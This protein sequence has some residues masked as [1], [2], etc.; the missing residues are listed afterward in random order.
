MRV[1]HSASRR[2]RLF[3]LLAVS[4]FLASVLA[5]AIADT[6]EDAHRSTSSMH[7]SADAPAIKLYPPTDAEG[8]IPSYVKEFTASNSHVPIYVAAPAPI[9]QQ[10]LQEGA[11][12]ASPAPQGGRHDHAAAATRRKREHP[13]SSSGGFASFARRWLGLRAPRGGDVEAE[14]PPQ[15]DVGNEDLADP[16]L[17]QYGCM[18]DAG[19]TGSRL[20]LYR[21]HPRVRTLHAVAEAESP[22]PRSPFSRPVTQGQGAWSIKVMPGLSAFAAAPR[23]A[24]ASLSPL[25]E[26]ALRTMRALGAAHKVPSSPVFLKATGGV[27]ALD[28]PT[29]R[30]ILDS[31][32]EALLSSGF[33]FR[34]GFARVISGEEEGVY[35]WLT[36]NYLLSGR[37]LFWNETLERSEHTV[38]ALDLGGA[39]MQA[40]FRPFQGQS[41]L[42]HEY[43]LELSYTRNSLYTEC[44]WY[45]GK[46]SALWRVHAVLFAASFSDHPSSV[47]PPA[48]WSLPVASAA[49][50]GHDQTH[51]G[52]PA[53][54]LSADAGAVP[55]AQVVPSNV[56][57]AG[58]KAAVVAATSTV[59]ATS[60]PASATPVLREQRDTHG[61]HS[62]D[63]ADGVGEAD[64]RASPDAAHPDLLLPPPSPVSPAAPTAVPSRLA[65]APHAMT[66]GQ[67]KAAKKRPAVA[68]LPT[69]AGEDA[70]GK[71]KGQAAADRV[72]VSPCLPTGFEARFE[73][74]Q[75]ALA[76]VRGEADW[77]RCYELA[78]HIINTRTTGPCMSRADAQTPVPGECTSFFGMYKPDFT[79]RVFH[80]F[81]GFSYFPSFAALPADASLA[82]VAAA[83]KAVCARP[84]AELKTAFP[85]AS[86]YYLRSYCWLSVYTVALLHEGFGFPLEDSRL[87]WTPSIAG[88]DVTY[89]LGAMLYEVNHLPWRLSADALAA[90][91]RATAT[92]YWWLLVAT[93]GVLL[94]SLLC[95]YKAG[96]LDAWLPAAWARASSSGHHGHTHDQHGQEEDS[97]HHSHGHGHASHLQQQLQLQGAVPGEAD[98]LLARGPSG[99]VR[100]YTAG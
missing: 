9:T 79:H 45:Y 28:E 90:G 77:A 69:T 33:L 75:D 8:R 68:P 5:P 2:H 63:D 29:R 17:Y 6:R 85:Q 65:R 13:S 84:W 25:I 31:V 47:H 40:T 86:R 76:V 12:P 39:S 56:H 37:T 50:D 92:R 4:L 51:D 32:S 71:G 72:F 42:A 97:H 23:A 88:T 59:A 96:L 100:N 99:K 27:R 52:H 94:A 34:P 41:I 54:V 38:G 7:S 22:A 44:F 81:S 62:D 58:G 67:I 74:G 11:V 14:A 1:Q 19:S 66:K 49:L 43:P 91:E 15:H 70:A 60:P 46:D 53:L 57:S 80:A 10:Q 89:A 78:R 98:S 30:A 82:D 83:G 21:W 24:G 16:S 35:G 18:I 3:C 95:N 87:R 48:A 73:G 64:V 93:A 61:K 26:F 36:V 55:T 20:Y